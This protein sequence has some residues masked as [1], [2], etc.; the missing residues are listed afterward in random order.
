MSETEQPAVRID[1]W[2]WAVRI[3][4]TR[5]EAAD[6]C[7]GSAVR[8]NGT[9]A[10]PSAKLRTGDLVTARTSALTRTLLVTGL[11]EKRVGAPRVTEFLEDR[12]PDSERQGAKEKH[13]NARLYA[14]DQG[15]RPTKKN[16][17]DIE[18]ILGSDW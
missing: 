5:N 7:R 16:R 12:T 8:L 13:D 15:G 6:A 3:Y 9:I 2:L 18:R 4:K 1:K 10:K 17:R 11:T 14:L